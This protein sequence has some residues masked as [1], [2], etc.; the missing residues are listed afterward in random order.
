MSMIV[1]TMP[2]PPE[3]YEEWRDGM[4]KF[5]GAR[6]D[7]YNAARTRQGVTRQGVFVDHTP[8]GPVEIM[9]LEAD[10]PERALQLITTSEEPFDVEF[11]EFLMNIFGL[12]LSKPPPGPPPEKVLDWSAPVAAQSR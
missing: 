5:S 2:I 11:R 8:Q 4:S 1:M 12:D 10:D 9:V 6:R 7:E 3:K